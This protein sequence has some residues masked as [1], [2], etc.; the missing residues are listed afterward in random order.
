ME[1]KHLK[2]MS[3]MRDFMHLENFVMHI[4]FWSWYLS[5]AAGEHN[6]NL[7]KLIGYASKF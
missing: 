1:S 3:K 5:Y 4:T 7:Q 2:N 6:E